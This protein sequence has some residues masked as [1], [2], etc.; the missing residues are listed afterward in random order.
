MSWSLFLFVN[1]DSSAIGSSRMFTGQVSGILIETFV[2]KFSSRRQTF[3]SV[4]QVVLCQ[5]MCIP[6]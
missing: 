6:F 5:G 3:I 1:S 4:A 2:T